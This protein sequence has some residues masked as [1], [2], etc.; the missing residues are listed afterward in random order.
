MAKT[1][2]PAQGTPGPEARAQREKYWRALI[3][4]CERSRLS[5]PEFCDRKSINAGTLS[6]WCDEIRRRD[7][8]RQAAAP[9]QRRRK[10][11]TAAKPQAFVP[12]R[13]IEPAPRGA[14]LEVVIGGRTVRVPAGFDPADLT[15]LIAVLE[16]RTC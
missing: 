7:H 10:R 14:S 3:Q 15:N 12:V 5:R 11:R 1:E 13:L 9:K 8:Q 6:W 4:E 16:A 2:Y